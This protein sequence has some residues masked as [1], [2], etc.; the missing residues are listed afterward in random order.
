MLEKLGLSSK[1]TRV[2][3]NQRTRDKKNV[4]VWQDTISAVI[5]IDDFYTGDAT[6]IKGLYRG[7]QT[8]EL[9]IGTPDFERNQDAQR[10][11]NV[12]LPFVAGKKM[13]DFG[14]GQGDFLKQIKPHCTDVLGIE[15]QQNYLKH[16]NDNGV[17]CS[18]S[19]ETIADNSLDI[20]VS[21]HVIEHLPD[22]L[23]VLTAIKQKIHSGGYVII[24]VPHARDFLLTQLACDDFK[25]FTLWSQHLLLHTRQSLQKM[26]AF[27]GFIDIQ[28]EGVQRYS[29]SNHL[30]WLS[31]GK[32][33]GHKSTL[34]M[35]ES[36]ALLDAY[37]NALARVDATDTLVAIAQV[38]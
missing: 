30:H 5:Y 1:E 26:L 35:I 28:I 37:Q 11:L 12:Y 6:Y 34:A 2:L 14:C 29:L 15:L 9:N 33:G 3:F 25:Q 7:R 31:H 24:E 27:V 4:K 16:L 20:V 32:P 38:T 17:P 8:A 23:T 10:R 19:L 36:N 22:P 18:N 13:A 21:F